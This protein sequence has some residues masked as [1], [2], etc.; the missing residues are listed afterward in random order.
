LSREEGVRIGLVSKA[1]LKDVFLEGTEV[2]AKKLASKPKTA[3]SVLKKAIGN[4]MN[5][6]LQTAITYENDC[7]VIRYVSESVRGGL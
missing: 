4:G 3:M 5:M 2:W 1:V 6:D 7:C